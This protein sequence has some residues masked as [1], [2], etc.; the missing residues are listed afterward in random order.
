MLQNAC[1][2]ELFSKFYASHKSKHKKNF[3]KGI[4]FIFSYM[5]N[6]QE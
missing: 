3:E 2:N 6:K 4:S 5:N 1:V